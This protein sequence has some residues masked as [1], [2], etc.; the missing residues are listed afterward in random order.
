MTVD[1]G[2][3]A[4]VMQVLTVFLLTYSATI[5][6]ILLFRSTPDPFVEHEEPVIGDASHLGREP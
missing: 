6:T 2:G 3:T 5:L 1:F 4:G